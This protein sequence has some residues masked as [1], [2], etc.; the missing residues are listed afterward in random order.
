MLGIVIATFIYCF[1]IIT[2]NYFIQ[3]NYLHYKN[4]PEQS[5]LVL[6]NA[7]STIRQVTRNYNNSKSTIVY[8]KE[9][10]LQNLK[11]RNVEV[12]LD[13]YGVEQDYL[14]F[15]L[16]S[17]DTVNS[18]ETTKLIYGRDFTDNDFFECRRVVHLRLSYAKLLFGTENPLGKTITIYGW[19][20][21]VIGILKDTPDVLRNINSLSDGS[22]KIYIP[23]TSFLKI[24][25]DHHGI[26]CHAIFRFNG[27]DLSE[28]DSP[29]IATKYSVHKAINNQIQDNNFRF[30]IVT[31]AIIIISAI[32]I[33]IIMLFNIKDRIF[34]IGIK[35]AIG[36]TKDDIRFQFLVEGAL[37]ALIGSMIG[38]FLGLFVSLLVCISGYRDTKVF[39][40]P[41]SA[42]AILIPLCLSSIIVIISSLIPAIKA[43]NTNIIKCLK[44]D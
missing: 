37:Y 20:Y 28:I 6:S 33:L 26:S 30:S 11:E 15:P 12:S 13:I 40:Y 22:L 23:Q 42:N 43:S 8:E 9:A 19:E 39:I 4:F 14:F 27:Y 24:F 3:T 25:G 38:I 5:M 2:G 7:P 36:A 31:I 21:Q 18:L 17:H 29:H 10:K 44:V 32:I 34:E 1:G 16:K 41:L 35:R